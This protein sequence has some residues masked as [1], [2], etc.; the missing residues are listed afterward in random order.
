MTQRRASSDDPHPAISRRGFLAAGTGAVALSLVEG[1]GPARAA[2][3]GTHHIPEDKNLARAWVASL[4]ARGH[5]KVYRG[6]ELTCTGMPVG[7]ICAGQLYLRGDG[8][9][10]SWQIF[11]QPNFTGYGENC[12]RTYTPPAPVGQGFALWV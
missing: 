10:A 1:C 11:N 7:G 5:S 6:D 4:Y 3:V 8:T 12:Y 9:L 2:K